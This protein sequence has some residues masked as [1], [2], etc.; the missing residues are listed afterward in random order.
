[1]T[2]TEETDAPLAEKSKNELTAEQQK[3]ALSLKT[4]HYNDDPEKMKD[5]LMHHDEQGKTEAGVTNGAEEA[6]H[7]PGRRMLNDLQRLSMRALSL[8]RDPDKK[9]P[10]QPGDWGRPGELTEDEVKVYVSFG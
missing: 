6:P 1:M 9:D 7:S 2:I 10:Q 8:R 4:L 5:A 3:R